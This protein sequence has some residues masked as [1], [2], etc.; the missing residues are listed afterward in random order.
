MY[1]ASAQ[2]HDTVFATSPAERVLITFAGN[3]F[4]TGEDILAS[5]GLKFC[6]AV[7]NDEDLTIGSCPASTLEFTVSNAHRLLDGY[8]Y[9]ECEALLGIKTATVVSGYGESPYAVLRYGLDNE[10]VFRGRQTKPW[11]TVNGE[12]PTIQ[13]PFPVCAILV[14][15][16]DI[17]CI[18][19]DGR[20]WGASWVDGRTWSAAAELTWGNIASEIWDG[21][22]GY[23]APLGAGTTWNAIAAEK[24][25]GLE[26]AQTV[27]DSFVGAE[28]I[29]DF[30]LHK[31]AG[32]AAKRRG[33]W[34]NSG[35]LY[36]FGGG[37]D[38]Y[39]YVPLGRFIP[40]KPTKQRLVNVALTAY[41]RMSKFDA[42]AAGFLSGL[43]YPATLGVFF[44]A[45]CTYVDVPRATQTFI[46]STRLL[47]EAPAQ[48]EGVTCR[49]L[50]GW[51][52]EAACAFAR[53][54]RDGEV[55][56]AWFGAEAVNIP[57][58]R[59]F[60]IEPEEYAVQQIDKLQ[61]KSAD[62][63][64]GVILGSG[65]NAYVILDNPM[66]YGET[67]T[68]VRTYATPIYNRLAA[69][70][71]YSPM[72]ARAICDWSVQ[73]GDVIEIVLDDTTY[74]LPVFHQEITWNGGARVVYESTGAELRSVVSAVNRR[75][76]NQRRAI[77]TVDTKING[78]KTRV[79]DT[80]NSAFGAVVDGA[81][82]PGDTSS[83]WYD[84]ISNQYKEYNSEDEEWQQIT[85]LSSRITSAESSI[86]Q[87]AD[88]IALVVTGTALDYSVNTA[89]IVAAVNNSG[90]E[91]KI[92]ADKI[93]MT[94]TTTFLT[95]SDVGTA[96]GTTINGSN[97]TTGIIKSSNYASGSAGTAINMTD[98]TIDTKNFKIAQ[99][100]SV[101]ATGNITA[102]AIAAQSQIS[103]PKITGG[104]I[105]AASYKT[106]NGTLNGLFMNSGA[107]KYFAGGSEDSAIY[108][109]IVFSGNKTVWRATTSS[110]A[111]GQCV[112]G[113][114]PAIEIGFSGTTANMYFKSL[115]GSGN[116]L[117]V[118]SSTG[119]VSRTTG[120]SGSGISFEYYNGAFYS[121]WLPFTGNTNYSQMRFVIF[122]NQSG[123]CWEAQ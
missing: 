31:F 67:D 113:G 34:Y 114:N 102:N 82:P 101:T 89:S 29:N 61:V 62:D 121:N 56:L 91:V 73:A 44:Q 19:A 81:E 14:N 68:E 66:L 95:A 78:V 53:M 26:S 104:E 3:T 85:N 99:D 115:T 52:A 46:N 8:T 11:F 24:W 51:I 18:A 30:M 107:V 50:L 2:F 98:G 43:T 7:N 90:S 79:I 38:K 93:Q 4:F 123:V 41:D 64:I 87:Q 45:L 63:D 105:S 77:V 22:Q 69:F 23:L 109:E 25:N 88:K 80:A 54:T 55:E 65:S 49:E 5:P 106:L 116:Y 100:G 118:D 120:T 36:E 6:E 48:F 71:E 20:V 59:Y 108:S 9:G 10:V 96:G 97:I 12:A 28:D 72:S 42:D 32:W 112:A 117:Y 119:L 13:P 74:S 17:Y 70:A 110:L 86:T 60:A 84:T 57:M 76:Y 94:G 39:E 33:L 27:W 58:S 92:K 35:T 37:I 111:I 83:V 1:S 47:A 75:V 16:A 122:P 15:S 103:S 40:V 21:I